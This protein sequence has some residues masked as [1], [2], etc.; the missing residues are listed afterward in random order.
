MT[1]RN[2]QMAYVAREASLVECTHSLVGVVV[3]VKQ[4]TRPINRKE[5]DLH[6]GDG[7][8]WQLDRVLRCRGCGHPFRCLPS[9]ILR[10]F[11]PESVPDVEA[12]ALAVIDELVDLAK[13]VA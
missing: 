7:Q 1:L 9:G 4:P 11:D 12:D 10:P 2:G 8:L 6:Y 3:Q 5:R 13:G